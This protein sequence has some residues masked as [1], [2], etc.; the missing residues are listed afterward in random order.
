MEKPDISEHSEPAPNTPLLHKVYM[1]PVQL[2][3][4]MCRQI[5][6]RVRGLLR[7]RNDREGGNWS[8]EG[9]N[10]DPWG[11]LTWVLDLEVVRLR[12]VSNHRGS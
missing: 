11:G 12:E 3:V 2:T 6:C 7:P 8:G 10:S 9:D 5:D 1:W 4:S